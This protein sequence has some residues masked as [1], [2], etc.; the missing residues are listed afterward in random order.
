MKAASLLVLL[1]PLIE[2][3]CSSATA[4]RCTP[5]MS[6][7]CAC[8]SGATGAQVCNA[9]GTFDS[10][11]CTSVSNNGNSNKRLFISSQSY[12]GNLKLNGQGATGVG[13]ADNLCNGLAMGQRLGGTWKAW[14]SDSTTNAID[15]IADVGP[16]Y[17]LNGTK[18]FNNKAGL[19]GNALATID[20]NEAGN[21]LAGGV[22]W[23]GTSKTGTQQA[24]NCN[25]WTTEDSTVFGTDG[26]PVFPD[27]WSDEY[28]GAGCDSKLGLY[29]FEQ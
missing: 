5:G 17:L 20:I 26:Q 8:A 25:D 29:C 12:S 3:A 14:I 6:E 16:W 7:A 1:L 2:I 11:N 22:V 4:G 15:R 18:V 24:N 13:G 19:S 28:A 27:G 23:T 10:C 9:G 21:P